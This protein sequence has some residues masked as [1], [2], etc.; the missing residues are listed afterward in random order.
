[1]IIVAY[2]IRDLSVELFVNY[3]PCFQPCESLQATE[4]LNTWL[5]FVGGGLHP[6]V[7]AREAETRHL[8]S[9]SSRI[10]PL[11]LSEANNTSKLARSVATAILSNILLQSIIGS[12][13]F[14]LLPLQLCT[15]SSCYASSTN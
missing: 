3:T 10:C 14:N 5:A 2:H 15:N 1:M 4:L 6:A 11:V 9:L 8:E 13:S 7:R 12:T